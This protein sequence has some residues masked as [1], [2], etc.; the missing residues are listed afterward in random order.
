MVEKSN[1]LG[2]ILESKEEAWS[3]PSGIIAMLL[4]CVFVYGALFATGY[5]IYG[6]TVKAIIFT[7]LVF[8]SAIGLVRI[9]GKIKN[10]I[11]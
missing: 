3:V 6:Y 7:A 4:G 10:K 2:N 9:W 1:A 8:L 5:W 11:L